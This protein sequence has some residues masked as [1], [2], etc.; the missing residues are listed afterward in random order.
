MKMVNEII[1]EMNPQGKFVF[2]DDDK[3]EHVSFKSA[4]AKYCDNEVISA[5]NGEE[6]F[7][8]IKENKDDIFII[9]CDINMP[10]IN[11]LELKRMIEG[12]PEL[13]L[14]AI[15]FI[16]HSTHDSGIVVKEAY[17][18]G[19]QGFIKKSADI[20]ESVSHLGIIIELWSSIVHPNVVVD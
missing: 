3:N 16:F 10:R 11:G 14:K 15:P 2:I 8:L 5:Y 9:I 13:K 4:L 18:L 20:T 12:T 7:N 1:P 19:I 17:A 6:A